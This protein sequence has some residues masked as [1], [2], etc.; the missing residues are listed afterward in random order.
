MNKIRTILIDDEPNALEVLEMQLQRNCP[1]IE[2]LATCDGGQMGIDAIHSLN[3]D[4][5]FLDIEMPH[6][7]GFDVLSETSGLKYKVIFTTAYDQFA[8]RAF[9]F[10]AVDY[11]LK[12][13]DLFELKQAVEK[14]VKHYNSIDFE[15][16]LQSLIRNF[17]QNSQPELIALPV[18]ESTIMLK[19]Q[20]IV[21]CE[22]ES[23]YTYIYLQNQKKILVAK[24]LKDVEETLSGLSFFRIHQSHLINLNHIMKIVKNDGGYVVMSDGSNLTIARSRKEEFLEKFRR[25]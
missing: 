15:L 5:V 8:I 16:R 18:G 2:V 24:T 10:S 17:S 20:D 25:I 14:A 23:N 1:E 4:L 6:K 9:R 7:N 22:S 12:P 11:L 3:P 19:P 21:R 13:V